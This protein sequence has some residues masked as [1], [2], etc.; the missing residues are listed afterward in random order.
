MKKTRAFHITNYL[1]FVGLLISP[2]LSLGANAQAAQPQQ[3]NSIPFSDVGNLYLKSFNTIEEQPAEKL[4]FGKKKKTKFKAKQ[5]TESEKRNITFNAIANSGVFDAPTDRPAPCDLQFFKKMEVFKGEENG[6]SLLS[7][8]D[9]T[10]TIFGKAA[11]VNMLARLT[12]DAAALKKR[13]AVI[14]ELVDNEQLFGQLEQA[15]QTIKGAESALLS[16]FKEESPSNNKLFKKVYFN[17]RLLKPLNKSAI[18]LEV[19]VG[20]TKK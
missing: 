6:S 2:A 16:Y 8:I 20:S 9:R 7:T 4:E 5:L 13:Q 19:G 11:L 1:L 10:Q 15:L 3:Q 18:A 14:K 12:P 17:S